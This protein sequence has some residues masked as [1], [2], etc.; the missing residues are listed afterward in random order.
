MRLTAPRENVLL[1]RVQVGAP[2]HRRQYI[3]PRVWRCRVIR[4]QHRS[5]IFRGNTV[6][7]NEPAIRI[8][9][10]AIN[11]LIERNRCGRP[12]RR[13][14]PLEADLSYPSLP[15]SANQTRKPTWPSSNPTKPDT[16]TRSPVKTQRSIIGGSARRHASPSTPALAGAP[17]GET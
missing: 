14:A 1:C 7:G 13:A 6:E 8:E 9:G 15:N 17:Q 11:G 2:E 10:V 5:L 16:E 4:Q 12:S 3:I